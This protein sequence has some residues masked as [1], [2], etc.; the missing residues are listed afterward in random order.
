MYAIRSYYGHHLATGGPH[1]LE[2]TDFR[3]TLGDGDEHHVHDENPCHG[4]ADG[5]NAGHGEGKGGEDL[6]EGGQNRILGP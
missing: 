5:R 6:V 3:V 2:K 4:Q 1:R